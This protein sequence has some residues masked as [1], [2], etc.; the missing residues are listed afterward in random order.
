MVCEKYPFAVVFSPDEH[1]TAPSRLNVLGDL[2][3]AL[4]TDGE[5]L[6]HYQPKFTLDGRSLGAGELFQNHRVEV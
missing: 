2:R 3:R 5:L 1:V 6:L 4:D